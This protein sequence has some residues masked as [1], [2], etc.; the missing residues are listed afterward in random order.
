MFTAGS[1]VIQQP[2]G[3]TTLLLPD[4]LETRCG[5]LLPE[6]L[7]LLRSQ[8]GKR[9][10]VGTIGTLVAVPASGDDNATNEWVAISIYLVG[11]PVQ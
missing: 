1:H 6:I 3:I 2:A 5:G 9:H 7:G 10:D 11:E 4:V 8:R